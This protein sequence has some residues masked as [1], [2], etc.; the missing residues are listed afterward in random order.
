MAFY[1]WSWL[2]VTP[3]VA[4]QLSARAVV[5]SEG[6]STSECLHLSLGQ[7]QKIHVQDWSSLHRTSSLITVAFPKLSQEKTKFQIEWESEQE[8]LRERPHSFYNFISIG[9]ITLH[10]F[11]HIVFVRSESLSLAH[12]QRD[13]MHNLNIP[14]GRDHWGPSHRLPIKNIFSVFQI[15]FSQNKIAAYCSGILQARILE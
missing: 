2:K 7:P 4:A 14:G 5:S 8:Y 9:G 15:Y 1:K 3:E 10:C 13:M 11:C 6:V 12:T